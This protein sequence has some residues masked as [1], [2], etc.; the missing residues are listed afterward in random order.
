MSLYITAVLL[1]IGGCSSVSSTVTDVTTPVGDGVVYYMPRRPIKVSI[2]LPAPTKDGAL[3]A[4]PTVDTIAA[5]PDLHRRFLLNFRANWLGKNHANIGVTTSG[6]LTTSN[7]DTTS[8]ISTIVQN[9]AKALGSATA[10]AAAV[11]APPGATPPAPPAPSCLQGRTYTILLYPEQYVDPNVPKPQLCGFSITLA[12]L[13]GSPLP[14]DRTPDTPRLTE[15][16][17]QS[18]VFYRQ[19]MP[20]RVT[21]ADPKGGESSQ[22]IAFSPN[23]SPIAYIPVTQGFFAN[24]QTNITLSEGMVTAVDSLTTG[25][26]VAFTQLPADFISAYAAALGSVFASFSTSAKAE[27]DLTNN[28]SQLAQARIK[29]TACASVIE[30]NRATLDPGNLVGVTG[31]ALA[32]ATANINAALANI[33]AA[34]Q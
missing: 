9:I 13:D 6:L 18:G 4:T 12:K 28:Q 8:G 7:A 22:F 34:C 16:G 25:E 30:A 33:K 19:E 27:A 24:N 11:A 31:D 32:K 15:K 17:K 14:T 20:Y 2:T 21:V 26:V 3:P 23:L 1:T 5:S 10:L 29:Q